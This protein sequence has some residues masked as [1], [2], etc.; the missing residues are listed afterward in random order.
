ML[1][2]KDARILTMADKEFEKGSILIK[3]KVRPQKA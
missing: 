3:D 1:L 2:I